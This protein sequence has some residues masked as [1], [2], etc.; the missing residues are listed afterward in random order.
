MPESRWNYLD[1]RDKLPI[2]NHKNKTQQYAISAQ[3]QLS[4]FDVQLAIG[5]VIRIKGE[6][7]WFLVF[8]SKIHFGAIVQFRTML[9]H[10]GLVATYCDIDLGQH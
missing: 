7:E 1:K 9:I 5:Y 2:R 8:D 10:Y 4:A 6:Q 3:S